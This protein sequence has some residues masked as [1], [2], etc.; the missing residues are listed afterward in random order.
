MTSELRTTALGIGIVFVTATSAVAQNPPPAAQGAPAVQGTA[1][2]QGAGR[3]NAQGNRPRPY[4]QVIT[5]RAKTE[6]GLI[7]VHQ[8]DDRF[9]IEIPDSA[10]RREFLMVSRISGVPAGSG[11]FTSAGS[12][13]EERVIRFERVGER[14]MMRSLAYGAVADDSLPVARSVA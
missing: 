9:F 8:I 7:T 6:R 5:E 3:G 11:G 12:S 4:S 10:T 2:A 14:V 13:R 1:P